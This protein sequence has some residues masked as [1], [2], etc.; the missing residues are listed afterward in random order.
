[1]VIDMCVHP[2]FIEEICSDEQRIAFR[3]EH[4]GLYKQHVWPLKL[5]LKQLD[6]AGIDKAV[7]IPEDLATRCGGQII[8]NEE[9]KNL[10]DLAPERMI[11]FASVDPYR[12]DAAQVLLVLDW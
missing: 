4:F 2:G 10:I 5:F 1:M 6:A 8:T 9:V 12:E 11:G 3:R 7:I